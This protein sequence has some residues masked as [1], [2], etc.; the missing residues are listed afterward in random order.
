MT[1]TMTEGSE[2]KQI[3]LFTLPIMAG[4]FLQQLYN[5]VDGIVVGNFGGSTAQE[6]AIALSSVGTCSPLTML[7]VAAAVGMSAGCGIMIA[8]YFGAK[9]MDEMKKAIST[10]LILL[11]GI[12]LALSVIGVSVS[13]PLLQYVLKVDAVY[14]PGAVT[15]FSIYSIGL[16]FQFIYNAAAAILRS[17]GDSKATLYFLLIASVINVV[18]DLVFVIVFGW[19]VMGVAVATVIA[20]AVSA[21]ASIFYMFRKYPI[22][23]FTRQEFRF[24]KDKGAIAFKLGIPTTLQQCVISTGHIAIQR[25][26]NDF[27]LTTTGLMAAYTASARVENF[28]MIPIFGF[29]VGLSTFTGQNI[30]AGKM[31]RVS[32]GLWSTQLM[33]FITCVG[34]ALVTYFCARPLVSLFGV[35]GS[36]LEIGITYLTFVA[37]MFL[38][39]CVYIVFNGVLQGSGDVVFLAINT[40]TSLL[41][42]CVAA[43]VL[44]YAT[45][46]G[47]SA[48]WVS[49]P[50]GWIYS[51]ILAL[52]RY[53]FGPWRKKSIIQESVLPG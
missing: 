28:I 44:A 42:R 49:M 2:W 4:N 6:C 39:F 14:L 11:A 10:T 47:Y 35:T 33:A 26:V 27:E 51:L 48:I 37:P 40:I 7:F 24:H 53:R 34:L 19:G 13:R 8:Q 41:I 12:G 17:L 32:R 22:L 5:T 18:L 43:Y 46:V 29:N 30:G 31:N 20:Q 50:I 3:L 15:Y 1:K 25:I 38:I 16:A 45:P 23:R 36:A 52:L 9:L 21:G